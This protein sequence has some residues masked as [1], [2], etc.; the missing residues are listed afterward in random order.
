MYTYSIHV[1]FQTKPQLVCQ[2]T[3]LSKK[4]TNPLGNHQNYH[5]RHTQCDVTSR[6]NQDNRQTQ[7][8]ANYASYKVKR[9]CQEGQHSK[10]D[11][12]RHKR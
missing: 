1:C 5:D 7:S 6:L 8:H 12:E 11:I 3:N 9:A 4:I 2:M 10:V